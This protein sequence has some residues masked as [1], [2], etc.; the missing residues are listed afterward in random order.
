[1]TSGTTGIMAEVQ[2]AL[3]GTVLCHEHEVVS[4][5]ARSTPGRRRMLWSPLGATALLS[6]AFECLSML[7]VLQIAVV[8]LK[9]QLSK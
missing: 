7:R 4:L 8:T 1:M 9:L 6:S 2:T 3:V 5:G